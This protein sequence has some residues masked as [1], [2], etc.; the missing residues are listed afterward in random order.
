MV[1]VL[2]RNTFIYLFY[3]Q[4]KA[5]KYGLNVNE[6]VK[7][8]KTYSYNSSKYSD[9]MPLK[10]SGFF[11]VD[12]AAWAPTGLCGLIGMFN[13]ERFFTNTDIGGFRPQQEW[14]QYA[15]QKDFIDLEQL[16]RFVERC[17]EAVQVHRKT[18]HDQ[19]DVEKAL[20]KLK[21]IK[22]SSS[23][24]ADVTSYFTPEEI[25][26]ILAALL[27]GF[28]LTDAYVWVKLD[29]G[30][31]YCYRLRCYVTDGGTLYNNSS[32]TVKLFDKDLRGNYK[33]RSSIHIALSD[34]HFSPIRHA[35][36]VPDIY[37]PALEAMLTEHGTWKPTKEVTLEDLSEPEPEV[38]VESASV[39]HDLSVASM[40][41]LEAVSSSDDVVHDPSVESKRGYLGKSLIALP[42][43]RSDY[44]LALESDLIGALEWKSSDLGRIVSVE[45]CGVTREFKRFA[46]VVST[47]RYCL[48]TSCE[49]FGLPKLH[50][51]YHMD[52]AIF[53]H[54]KPAVLVSMTY[55]IDIVDIGKPRR[56]GVRC[57]FL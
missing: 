37:L 30:G 26:T 27:K 15:H 24:T 1:V 34:N 35:V 3:L 51:L 22:V 31:R 25:G 4:G 17:M 20:V 57:L 56:V 47:R 10:L 41:A 33:D 36:D 38:S 7:Y 13:V 6:L 48:Y 2:T 16:I 45:I 54:E 28:P 50:K 11:S 52:I 19:S 8:L 12:C 49:D 39:N 18:F 43:R 23:M 14:A 21:R 46:A 32:V 29:K 9:V 53:A 44:Q 5:K 55:L 40:P 42:P